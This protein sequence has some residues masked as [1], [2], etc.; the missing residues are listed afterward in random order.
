MRGGE[1]T[2][3]GGTGNVPGTNERGGGG[4]GGTPIEIV[5]PHVRQAVKDLSKMACHFG[6]TLESFS[7]GAGRFAVATAAQGGVAVV[8]GW[9]GRNPVLLSF[10]GG[11]LAVGAAAGNLA[12]LAQFVGGLYQGASG[13]G[14]GNSVKA[15]G[16]FGLS[17]VLSSV[18]RM[19]IPRAF[20]N[21]SALTSE[22][23]LGG[24]VLAALQQS[25]NALAP[26]QVICN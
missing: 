16:S 24:N 19:S 20:R 4:G 3:T 23:R 2:S 15:A 1:P 7:E 22:R 11:S 21:E 18:F 12:G 26:T 8:V 5:A 25:A 9:A 13:H 14:F 17:A 10:G 6:N